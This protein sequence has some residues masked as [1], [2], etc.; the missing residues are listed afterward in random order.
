MT[1]VAQLA[2]YCAGREQAVYV[3]GGCIRDRLLGRASPDVDL[4]AHEAAALGRGFARA[5]RHVLVPLDLERGTWRVVSREPAEQ[6]DLSE[7][8][9]AIDADLALRDFTLNAIACPLE[10]WHAPSPAWIDPLGGQADLA[11]GRI[12][13]AGERSLLDDPLRT[14]RAYRFA[15]TL[16]FAVEPTTA[17][18]I[19]AAAPGVAAVAAE[20]IHQE[21][22]PLLGAEG[23][24]EAVAALALAG[25]LA[26]LL[27]NLDPDAVARVARL[28]ALLPAYRGRRPVADWLADDRLPLLRFAALLGP[29][30]GGSKWLAA[31]FALSRAE[32]RILRA[33]RAVPSE[34]AGRE[35]AA[36]LV[37]EHGES[38]LGAPG[39]AFAAGA[40]AREAAERILAVLAEEVLP[41][42]QRPAAIGGED[43]QVAL[44]RS[45]GP[46]FRGALAAVRRAELAGRVT[47]REAA[48]ALAEAWF[49]AHD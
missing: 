24:A 36:G 6:I 7:L 47:G 46:L 11:A 26:V 33:F 19:R 22:L 30:E 43:L 4:A 14:L 8:H 1:L 45:P 38:A 17:A 13:A 3:V 37:F 40:L 12:R 18:L 15:A 23:A 34:L 42:W 35:A 39:V 9:G 25:V 5:H 20:R 27:P 29:G 31:R 2:A 49:A 48:L 21:W 32:R 41:V 16:G 28:E 10:Q 44:G